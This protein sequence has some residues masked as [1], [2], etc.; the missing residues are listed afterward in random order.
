MILEPDT[1]VS[2]TYLLEPEENP[3]ICVLRIVLEGKQRLT[4][5]HYVQNIAKMIEKAE[6]R[7]TLKTKFSNGMDFTAKNEVKAEKWLLNFFIDNKI[8]HVW[9]MGVRDKAKLFYQE[10]KRSNDGKNDNEKGLETFA[11]RLKGFRTDVLPEGEGQDTF[12][13]AINTSDICG[14][15]SVSLAHNHLL[16]GVPLFSTRVMDLLKTDLYNQEKMAAIFQTHFIGD[17]DDSDRIEKCSSE[18]SDIDIDSV[19][20]DSNNK[21]DNLSF[22]RFAR[23]NELNGNSLEDKDLEDFVTIE[24][25]LF[26]H[27]VATSHLKSTKA[28]V[29]KSKIFTVAQ[30]KSNFPHV[31]RW[32]KYLETLLN[33][34]KSEIKEQ[35]F[36]VVCPAYFHALD[37]VMRKYDADLLL[38]FVRLNSF[39]TA[40]RKFPAVF[41]EADRTLF[42]LDGK[43]SCAFLTE[44]ALPDAVGILFSEHLKLQSQEKRVEKMIDYLKDA[45]EDM[46]DDQTWMSE[47]MKK[48]ATA[49]IEHIKTTIGI[50][51]KDRSDK[52][53]NRHYAKIII[54]ENFVQTLFSAKLFNMRLLYNSLY[55]KPGESDM[56]AHFL[57]NEA[58]ASY[59]LRENKMEINSG[60]MRHPFLSNKTLDIEMFA[61]LG[62]VISHEITHP[63]GLN[64]IQIDLDGKYRKKRSADDKTIRRYK[65]KL[66]HLES[67]VD[68]ACT[69][70]IGSTQY[71]PNFKKIKEELI[72]DLGGAKVALAAYK[73]YRGDDFDPK[74]ESEFFQ[75]MAAIFCHEESDEELLKNKDGAHPPDYC[76]VA[77]ISKTE[78][79]LKA[80]HCKDTSD[81]IKMW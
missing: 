50:P 13:C 22:K 12:L 17:Y 42:G 53:L 19:E 45:F 39:F 35:K 25:I 57:I 79:F 52:F 48:R 9:K 51:R 55:L 59:D 4:A 2:A 68:K 8:G 44:A 70:Q 18:A 73:N 49:K 81:A 5:S 66:H 40:N 31:V 60:I 64:S 76:R 30:L 37:E 47:D 28:F 3:S 63:I 80:N 21:K 33:R 62:F 24:K 72:A 11:E 16:S 65:S 27:S 23:L 1:S 29:K 6:D 26:K 56:L 38:E 69:K 46:I 77:V 7:S 20:Y 75:K 58:N 61:D 41:E 71:K 43:L 32:E 14:N 36:M 15:F 10:C 67:K 78:E 74:E 54:H 34:E